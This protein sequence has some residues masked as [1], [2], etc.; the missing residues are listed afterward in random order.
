MVILA[1]CAGEP[2][3]GITRRTSLIESGVR[4]IDFRLAL[5]QRFFPGG[6]EAGRLLAHRADGDFLDLEKPLLGAAGFLLEG[7][8]VDAQGFV[9]LAQGV[10][11][12]LQRVVAA[13]GDL[14]LGVEVVLEVFQLALPRA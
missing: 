11:F 7:G 3:P 13:G 14:E 6:G 10:E 1:A 8:V 9:L 12:G 4:G 5:A 2:S